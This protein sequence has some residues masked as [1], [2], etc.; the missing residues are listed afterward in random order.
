S[1]RTT[2][3]LSCHLSTTSSTARSSWNATRTLATATTG[4]CGACTSTPPKQWRDEGDTSAPIRT[5][6][7]IGCSFVANRSYFGEL[8]LLAWRS[9]VERTQTRASGC[10]CVEAVW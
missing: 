6:A 9:T 4:S 5:P 8:G 10:G 1:K 3:G 7:M 2:Q